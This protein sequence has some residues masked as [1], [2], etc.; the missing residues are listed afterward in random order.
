MERASGGFLPALRVAAR[1]PLYWALYTGNLAQALAIAVALAAIPYY[2]EHLLGRPGF[3]SVLFVAFVGPAV[4]VVPL[5]RRLEHRHGKRWCLIAASWL[6]A[7]SAALAAPA[8]GAPVLPVIAFIGCGS[9][10]AAQQLFAYS[11]LAD[12]L[13]R[14]DA[15]RDGRQAGLLAGLWSA[16]ETG[17]FAIGPAVVGALLGAFGFVS[18]TADEVVTQ[19]GSALLG[20]A[21]AM[22][23]I[24]AT[25]VAASTWRFRQYDEDPG[26]ATTGGATTGAAGRAAAPRVPV[27]ALPAERLDRSHEP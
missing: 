17:M 24:P 11:L 13:A 10:Y 3:T 15:G 27:V 9:A 22:G 5:W 20:I 7:G 2:S 18:S 6:F 25:L 4:L 8:W 12:T 23:V 16:S 26:A 19:P 21:L 14:H 1:S